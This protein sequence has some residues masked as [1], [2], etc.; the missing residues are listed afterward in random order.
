MSLLLF[1]IMGDWLFRNIA[2]MTT[3]Y[4]RSAGQTTMGNMRL[5][6]SV[7]DSLYLFLRLSIP[8]G[9]CIM[10][11]GV[12]ANLLQVGF[13][14]TTEPLVPK[15][16]KINPLTGLTR[17]VSGR[18]I[19]EAIRSILKI[20]VILL[21]AYR[22]IAGD[23]IEITEMMNMSL[24]AI[25]ERIVAISYS[26]FWRIILAFLVIAIL[27]YAYQ[28][29]SYEQRL[30]M[31]KQELKEERKQIDGDPAVKSRIRSLQREMARRRMMENVPKATVV[32]T[33]PTHLAIAIR[34]EP[35][36]MDAPHVIAKGKLLI[37]Q[38]IKE[39]ALLNNIPVVEDKKLAR[40]LYDIV[41]PGDA[42]P[43]Q[44]YSA[45]AEILA[46]IYKLK[47]KVVS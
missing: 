44:F 31:T 40:A 11:A 2:A 6:S 33:N 43:M 30:R 27:D 26:L 9:F 20:I 41:E 34:Y 39:I 32:V 13:L 37:A 21:I 19:V 47:N 23:F 4:L 12:L 45:V 15:M 16:E 10:V 5:V 29:Y 36:Q 28:R 18:S 1:R 42:I 35:S 17:L 8:F 24:L 14:F 25:W 46:Y 22:T 38:K 3:N 7:T